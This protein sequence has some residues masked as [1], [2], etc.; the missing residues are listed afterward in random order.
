MSLLTYILTYA[1]NAVASQ[2]SWTSWSVLN[3]E[4]KIGPFLGSSIRP[5]LVLIRPC[6]GKLFSS[7]FFVH[8]QYLYLHTHRRRRRDATVELSRVGVG[9]I[10]TIEGFRG[11]RG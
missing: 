10:N 7:N 8:A 3:A 5:N 9:G 2:E 11:R 6:W 1:D 4:K